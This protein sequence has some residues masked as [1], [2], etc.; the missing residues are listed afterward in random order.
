MAAAGPAALAQPSEP[1]APPAAGPDR[2]ANERLKRDYVECERLVARGIVDASTGM[3][4]SV[5]YE[6]LKAE[7]FAGDFAALNRWW[8]DERA[9]GRAAV[10]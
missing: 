4:C 6:K 7:A 5:V 3:A 2:D 9:R 1:R 10:R 8:Q